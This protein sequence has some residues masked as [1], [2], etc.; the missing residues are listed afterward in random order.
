MQTSVAIRNETLTLETIRSDCAKAAAELSV[1]LKEK[2][3]AGKD[4]ADAVEASRRHIEEIAQERNR[5][6][7]ASLEIEERAAQF[8]K[9]RDDRKREIELLDS[10]IKD[11]NKLLQ[12]I[13][14]FIFDANA[15]Y[16]KRQ[17]ELHDISLEIESKGKVAEGILALQNEYLEEE[18]KRDAIRLENNLSIDNAKAFVDAAAKEKAAAEQKRDEAIDAANEAERERQK[19]ILEKDRIVRDLNIY[20]SRVEAKYKEAFPELHMIL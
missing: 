14:G 1:I 6:H 17:G 13:Q 19:T 4:L 2:E 20:A 8:E 15:E 5:L 18:K 11:A 16:D 3:A 7:V 9:G 10:K 12:R